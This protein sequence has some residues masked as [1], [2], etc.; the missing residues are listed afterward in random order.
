MTLTT[1]FTAYVSAA[2]L[3]LAALSSCSE[4][5][6][7]FVINEK[8]TSSNPGQTKKRYQERNKNVLLLYSAG[9]NSLSSYLQADIKELTESW[10]PGD[11]P[12]DNVLLV[13]SRHTKGNQSNFKDPVMPVL[14][15]ICIGRDEQVLRDTIDVPGLTLTTMASDPK[16]LNT[17]LT[18]VRNNF[19]ADSYGMIF[20]SHATGWLPPGYYNRYSSPRALLPLA[21]GQE[22]LMTKTI[23]QEY[24]SSQ[25]YEMAVSE[26]AS[27]FPT[28]MKFDYILFDACLMGCVEVA[29]E[30]RDVCCRVAFSQA[31]V[32]AEGF[33]YSSITTRL[34][35]G[36]SPD[37]EGVCIDFFNLYDGKSGNEHSATISLV[38][39]GA[40][41]DLA[42][43]CADLFDKYRS[44]I[45]NLDYKT[46]QGYYGGKAHWF[47]DLEDILVKAGISQSEKSALDKALAQCVVYKGCTGQY[48]S[49]LDYSVHQVTTFSG[50]SMFLPSGGDSTLRDYY[51][52][53]LWNDAT[54]LIQ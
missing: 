42:D 43:V 31:E 16:T 34:L 9:Y 20:S 24:V 36:L 27:A 26:F 47:F 21:P 50:L 5:N 32:L 8:E 23:G 40:L 33:D 25:S 51:K 52:S 2:L 49:A 14:E 41:D 48:Y 7:D 15:R 10:L 22:R 35:K 46:V 37:I 44:A 45:Q 39:T 11:N 12:Y 30:L 29:Y 38:D 1:R 54:G 18:Y 28:G 6:D 3:A 19:E 4:K 17:V 13:F 53:Y